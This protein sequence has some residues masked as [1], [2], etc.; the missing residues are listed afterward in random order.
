MHTRVKHGEEQLQV[1]RYRID[2][3]ISAYT[4]P[5]QA[6]IR[7]VRFDDRYIHVE[8]TDGRILS[9]PLAWIPSVDNAP[10]EERTKYEQVV[11]VR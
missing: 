9:V 11:T 1:K 10:P 6:R 3:P 4:F 8:L 7:H 2:Y 5:R